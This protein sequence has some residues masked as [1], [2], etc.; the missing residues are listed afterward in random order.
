MN[1]KG[2]DWKCC[3]LASQRVQI[4]ITEVDTLLKDQRK[5]EIYA[6]GLRVAIFGPPNVGKS[7]LLN[8]FGMFWIYRDK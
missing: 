4:L 8:F 1:L 6:N 7:T 2:L 5:G 3:Y